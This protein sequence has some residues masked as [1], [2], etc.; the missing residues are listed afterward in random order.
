MNNVFNKKDVFN[1]I[2]Y[3]ISLYE[4]HPLLNA[5]DIASVIWATKNY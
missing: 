4:L 1:H 3:L 2:A 5:K